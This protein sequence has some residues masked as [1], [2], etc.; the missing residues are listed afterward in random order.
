MTELAK[1]YFEASKTAAAIEAVFEDYGEIEMPDGT[2][3][4][5]KEQLLEWY[6]NRPG[7]GHGR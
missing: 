3:M 6:E 7:E 5:T 1:K 4:G 2:C